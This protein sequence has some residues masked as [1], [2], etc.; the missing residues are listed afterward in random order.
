MEPEQGLKLGLRLEPELELPGEGRQQ[1]NTI[2][3]ASL[4]SHIQLQLEWRRTRR[5]T[6]NELTLGISRGEA[7]QL[8]LELIGRKSSFNY[9]WKKGFCFIKD[10]KP[11]PCNYSFLRS[12]LKLRR[13]SAWTSFFGASAASPRPVRERE[14]RYYNDGEQRSTTAPNPNHSFLTF[15]SLIARRLS[16]QNFDL[17]RHDLLNQLAGK[18]QQFIK[19]WT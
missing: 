11:I 14:G 4:R 10:N 8:H 19:C 17:F 1:I 7:S 3:R 5:T 13:M 18:S 15:T 2:T 9:N 6:G 12:S 16:S